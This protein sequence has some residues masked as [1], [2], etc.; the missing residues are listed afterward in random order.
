MEPKEIEQTL[1]IAAGLCVSVAFIDLIITQIKRHNAKKRAEALPPHN[2][3]TINQRPQDEETPMDE[4]EAPEI[5]ED[6]V[7]SP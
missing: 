7:P 6:A 5:Q 3:V 1:I 2:A 4:P